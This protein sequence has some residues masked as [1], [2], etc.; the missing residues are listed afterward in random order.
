MNIAIAIPL[1]KRARSVSG[2][3]K[4]KLNFW[5]FFD[6]LPDHRNQSI[7]EMKGKQDKWLVKED[8][9]GNNEWVS[10]VRW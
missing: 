4:K 10:N 6:W 7:E 5:F 8:D 1:L 3:Q 2:L 9:I